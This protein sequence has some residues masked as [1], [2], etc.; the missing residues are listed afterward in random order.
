MERMRA[1]FILLTLVQ[2]VLSA[3]WYTVRLDS[4]E[5]YGDNCGDGAGKEEMVSKVRIAG[6]TLT[7]VY[8][9]DIPCTKALTKWFP[10]NR[11]RSFSV[12]LEGWESD[13][14]S[15][16]CVAPDGPCTRKSND[17]CYQDKT[18][19]VYEGT[20]SVTI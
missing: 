5:E 15:S 9:C 10:W 18:K 14:S 11:G 8:P 19:T 2:G 4:V 20:S 1:L 16:E 3:T 6:T 17:D 7:T 12:Y 13:A